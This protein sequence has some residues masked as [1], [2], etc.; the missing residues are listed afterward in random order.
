VNITNVIKSERDDW[1]ASQQ[2]GLE[3][4][5]DINNGYCK[6]FATGVDDVVGEP[7][8]I[9]TW[10]FEGSYTSHAH[11]WIRYEGRCYDVECPQ[12]VK[13]AGELPIFQRAGI[14]P[15]ETD[16]DIRS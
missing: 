8:Q 10:G 9:E 4:A 16:I 13:E 11:A 7:I 6:K 15:S 3:T 5:E 1:L 14:V 12:G 2:L